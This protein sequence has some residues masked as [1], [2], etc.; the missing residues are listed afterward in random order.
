MVCVVKTPALAA[1]TP[2]P[3]TPMWDVIGIG[4]NSIDYVYRLPHYPKAGTAAK[5]QIAGQAVSPGGQVATALCACAAM[6][7]RTRYVG[8]FGN[9]DNA[10]RMREE[11]T[12]R[13]IDLTH[14]L[15]RNVPNR[16]AVILVDE[17]EG[18]R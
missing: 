17:R 13:G 8:T 9:D 10:A 7:L 16:Y 14:S 3:M 1:D 12:R 6:G 18:E 2:V 11:L 5:V 15:S 4:E